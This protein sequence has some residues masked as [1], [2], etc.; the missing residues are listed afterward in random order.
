MFYEYQ[1]RF[2][3][4]VFHVY[5]WNTW[6][7]RLMTELPQES[8]RDLRSHLADVVERADRYHQPTV[9]TRRGQPIAAVVS[10]D[11]LRRYQE[12]E[13][14]ELNRIVD[15]RMAHRGAGIPL[16]DVLRETLSRDD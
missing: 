8:I 5:T 6:Y 11:V 4:Q 16:E 2:P 7:L 10:I 14:Q 13:E 9:I 3:Y 1:I 15:E 12:L